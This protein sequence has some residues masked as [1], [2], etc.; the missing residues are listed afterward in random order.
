VE[1]QPSVP[2]QPSISSGSADA[3]AEIHARPAS[4]WRRAGATLIDT[5]LLGLVLVGFLSLASSVAGT[6]PKS[7]ASTGLEKLALHFHA[8]Q[9]VLVPGAILALVLG[10]AYAAVFSLLWSGR[11]PGRAIFGIRLVDSTGLS[12][13]PIRA[14]I[15]ALLAVVSFVALCAGFWLALFDR[16]GQTLH[17]K[18]TS[19][20]VVR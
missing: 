15:R 7:D 10:V 13:G 6:A 2:T 19:T 12:P 17:D 16:R 14:V 3:V 18:L 5:L 20:F 4:L 11:T 1:T 9:S 8:W